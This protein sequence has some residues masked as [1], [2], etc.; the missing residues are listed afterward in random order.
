[1]CYSDEVILK[2]V[3]GI[4]TTDKHGSRFCVYARLIH[5]YGQTIAYQS[6][7]DANVNNSAEAQ[8]S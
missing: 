6:D 2:H 3:T 1:M 4:Y 7:I 8:A 5:Y